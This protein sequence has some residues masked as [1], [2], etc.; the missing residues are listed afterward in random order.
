MEEF[1][2]FVVAHGYLLLAGWVFLDQLGVPIP[3]IPVLI[4]AGAV[5]STGQLNLAAAVAAAS[6]GSIPSD[7]I[8]Y[9]AGRRKGAKILRL[10]CK[11]TIE[12]DSCVRGTEDIFGRHGARS[13]LFAKFVPGYQT[14]APPLAGMSGMS[15]RRFLAFTVPGTVVW[16]AAFMAVGYVFGNQLDAAYRVVLE[17]GALALYIALGAFAIYIASRTIRRHLFIRHLRTQRIDPD[18]LM[19]L[20]DGD[21]EVVVYDLRSAME[22]EIE[23]R[24]IEGATVLHLEELDDRHEEIPRDREIILYCS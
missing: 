11:I 9:E 16:V 10:L 23:P 7:L 13:L 14:M 22:I 5:A 18:A 24:R 12:P 8:W 19:T 4:A 2:S 1:T 3:V 21:T 6:L 17:L 20:R 15:I